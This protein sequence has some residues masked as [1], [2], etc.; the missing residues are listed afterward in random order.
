[1]K[2]L[3]L[4]EEFSFEQSHNLHKK[5]DKNYD[6]RFESKKDIIYF[7][8]PINTYKT[9]IEKLCIEIIKNHFPN[10]SIINPSDDYYQL[11]FNKFRADNPTNY[12]IYFKYLVDKCSIVVY[13]PFKDGKI[14]AGIWYE[15]HQLIDRSDEIYSI[16]LN[17]KSLNKVSID[18][19]DYNKLSIEETRERIK[20]N[21]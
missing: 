21:Y 12:M 14:G 10:H 8:H 9:D 13:L 16:D 1:M 19:V 4:Y 2:I 17:N 3:K 18:Y 7:A 15:I 11:D 6:N 20:K 5:Y